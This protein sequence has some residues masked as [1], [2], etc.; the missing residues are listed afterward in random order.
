[1]I[2]DDVPRDEAADEV[3]SDLSLALVA[4][5]FFFGFLAGHL[6]WR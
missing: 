3:N 6:F 5:V 1:M 4:V 2:P